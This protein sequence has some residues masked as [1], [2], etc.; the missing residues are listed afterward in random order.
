MKLANYLFIFIF[1]SGC[2]MGDKSHQKIIKKLELEGKPYFN[3][4]VST[5]AYASLLNEMESGDEILICV[6]SL[7]LR[8]L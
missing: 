3:Q 5:Q 7:I 2:S 8:S 1:V 6:R 4:L